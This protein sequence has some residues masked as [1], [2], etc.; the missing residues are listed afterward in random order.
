[1]LPQHRRYCRSHRSDQWRLP[2]PAPRLVHKYFDLKPA[3]PVPV[4]PKARPTQRLVLRP[5]QVPVSLLLRPQRASS[6]SGHVRATAKPPRIVPPELTAPASSTDPEG[7][8]DPH[9]SFRPPNRG[10]GPG[11]RPARTPAEEGRQKVS[12]IEEPI[13]KEQQKK[14]QNQAKIDE[15]TNDQTTKN[16]AKRTAQNGWSYAQNP[17]CAHVT[18]LQPFSTVTVSTRDRLQ[19]CPQPK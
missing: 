5:L 8:D 11:S 18:K 13:Q 14:K 6:S 4:G 1:M 7:R 17:P 19:K 3:E 2:S 9:Y 16:E 10:Q 15:T 12:P